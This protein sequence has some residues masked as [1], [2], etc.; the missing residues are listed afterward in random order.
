MF[1]ARDGRKFALG[2][3]FAA[4]VGFVVGILTAPKSGKETRKDLKIS[5]MVA[6]RQAERDLK[7]AHTELKQLIASASLAIKDTSKQA[8]K[9]LAKAIERARKSQSKVRVLL[10]SIHDGTS[11][12]PELRQALDE[13]I[14]ARAH[15]KKFFDKK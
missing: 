6:A 10:S 15:L 9:D 11:D 4:T 7:S 3:I 14:A 12:D 1:K 2:A 5:T 13:A 8:K